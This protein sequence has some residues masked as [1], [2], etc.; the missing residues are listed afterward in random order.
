ML[1]TLLVAAAVSTTTALALPS[2]MRAYVATATAF[3]RTSKSLFQPTFPLPALGDLHAAYSDLPSPAC[4][5]LIKVAASSINPSDVAPGI[6]SSLLPHVMGSDVAGTVVSLSNATHCRVQLG[7]RVYGDI[8]ANTNTHTSPSE[9]T[10]ELG[11]YAEYTLA[12]DTQLAVIPSLLSFQEAASLPK[13]ALTSLKAIAIYGGGR[14]S[15]FRGSNVL[16]LGGSGGTG[17]TGI[18]L[19]KYFGA[20]N[21]TTTTSGANTD[22]CTALG[23][24]RVVDYHT[25]NWWNA[26]VTQDNAFDLVYDTVGEM[27]TG[28]RAMRVVKPGGYYVTITGQLAKHVKPGVRQSMF[29]NSDTNLNSGALMNELASISEMNALRMLRLSS[30]YA[31]EDIAK[32]FAASETGHVVGKVVVTTEKGGRK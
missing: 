12:L 19:A 11:A 18:Q 27:G 24:T 13:V 21:I 1:A 20:A 16:I 25:T 26:S 31:L 5:V 17:S 28:D 7:D 15:S 9:K 29:I 32:G 14:N 10:K 23:A 22:Y 4:E 30:P 2:T 8:G 6:A 3:G